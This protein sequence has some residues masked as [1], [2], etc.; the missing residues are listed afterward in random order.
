LAETAVS[1]QEVS[2]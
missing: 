2:C 1:W